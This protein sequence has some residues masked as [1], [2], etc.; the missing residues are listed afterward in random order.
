MADDV[1]DNGGSPDALPA[2]VE[3]IDALYRRLSTQR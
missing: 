1:V 2:Q 3:R